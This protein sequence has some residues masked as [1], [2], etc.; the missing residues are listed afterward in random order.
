[1]CAS[2][3]FTGAVFIKHEKRF[4]RKITF[5]ALFFAIF[6]VIGLLCA[7]YAALFVQS[8]VICIV[9]FSVYILYLVRCDGTQNVCFVAFCILAGDPLA[10]H[11][12]SRAN[13]LNKKKLEL[14]SSNT[15]ND[16]HAE[17]D[18]DRSAHI[19]FQ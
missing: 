2:L 10:S 9:A 5:S 14:Y 11:L 6:I 8:L 12:H 19:Y 18:T 13:F 4:I 15:S 17:T 3:K 7:R 1:M 16:F